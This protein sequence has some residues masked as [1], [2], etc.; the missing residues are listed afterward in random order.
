MTVG[1]II[2][3]TITS[4]LVGRIG[5]RIPLLFGTASMFVGLAW[6][7]RPTATSGYLDAGMEEDWHGG[8][9]RTNK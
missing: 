8:S 3:A 7:S 1:I 9:R 5:I 4:R 2:A 6:I